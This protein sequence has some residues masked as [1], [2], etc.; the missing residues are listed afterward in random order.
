MTS[1]YIP[2]GPFCASARIAKIMS[3]CC[4]TSSTGT[5]ISALTPRI[6]IVPFRLAS[7][8][9]AAIVNCHGS[10]SVIDGGAAS[11]GASSIEP[12][13]TLP[14]IANT[15]PARKKNLILMWPILSSP[16]AK[17]EKKINCRLID[18]HDLGA[19]ETSASRLECDPNEHQGK[20]DG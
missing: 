12:A 9:G 4:R 20:K 7:Q 3:R 2:N 18:P 13:P 5:S 14:M 6:P 1:P 8:P 17:S 10:L 11:F 15:A 19:L 16:S